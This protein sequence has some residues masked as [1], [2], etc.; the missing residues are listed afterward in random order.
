MV[1]SPRVSA[2]TQTQVGQPLT[3]SMGKVKTRAYNGPVRSN[4][5]KEREWKYQL[6][7]KANNL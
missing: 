6:P 3:Q 4:L 5:K 7:L 1:S 2:G